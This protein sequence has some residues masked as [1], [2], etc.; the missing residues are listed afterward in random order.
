MHG[1]SAAVGSQSALPVPE[2]DMQDVF[3]PVPSREPACN[4]STVKVPL[5]ADHLYVGA[6]RHVPGLTFKFAGRFGGYP[7]VILFDTGASGSFVSEKWLSHTVTWQEYQQLFKPR[8]LE[9]PVYANTADNNSA[10]I[11]T[12]CSGPLKIQQALMYIRPFV[13]GHLLHGVDVIVGMDALKK[14][15]V[16]LNC[17]FDTATVR[18][19]SQLKT[20]QGKHARVFAKDS[21]PYISVCSSAQLREANIAHLSAKQA[22]KELKRGAASWLMLVQPADQPPDGGMHACAA[23]PTN[24]EPIDDLMSPQTLAKLVSDYSDVFQPRSGCPPHRFDTSHT[25]RLKEGAQPTYR[26]PYRMSIVEEQEMR[27]Q[28]QE[29]L[30]KDLIEPSASPYGAPVLFVQKK[31]GSLRMCVDYRAL[32][33]ITVRDRYPLPRIDELLDRLHGCKVFSSLDLQSG[34]HQIRIADADKEKT[35]MVTSAGQFQFKVLCFGLTN[36]PAT[37]QRVM[38]KI[39][40]PYIGKFVLVYLD[41]ILVMS[42]SAAEHEHHLRT[43]LHI[44]R[45]NQLSAKLSK[46]EFNRPQLHFLGHVVGRDGISVDPDKIAVIRDWPVPTNLKQL[47]AFLGLANYFRRFV[48]HYSMIAA[49]LTELCGKK[50]ETY[51]WRNWG[52]DEL[53]AFNALKKALTTAPVLAIPDLNKPFKV[54]TDASVRGTGAILMQDDRVIAYSSAKFSPAQYNYTTGEQELLGLIRALEVWRCY[55]EYSPETIV[56]TDHHPLIHLQNQANL[57]RRQ[58]RWVEFLARF[59]FQIEFTP[60]KS[61]I[62]DIISR[63]PRHSEDM[64]LALCVTP[65][66]ISVAPAVTRQQARNTPPADRPTD[67]DAPEDG[68]ISPGGGESTHATTPACTS[69]QVRARQPTRSGKPVRSLSRPTPAAAD[70]GQV[71]GAG[72]GTGQCEGPMPQ[73]SVSPLT[74]DN[75]LSEIKNAYKADPFFSTETC[76]RGFARDVQGLWLLSDK[77]VVPNVPELRRKILWLCHDSLM[78]GHPGITKTMDLVAR[79]FFWFGLRKDVEYYVT[80]CEACQRNKASTAQRAGELQPLSIPSRR[81][82]SVSVDF[83]VKLPLTHR[84]HDTIL[85]C[86]DR[87]SKMVHLVP[88]VESTSAAEFARL[89]V[90][91]VVKLHGVPESI[92]SD[93]GPQFASVFWEQ[94][95]KLL[96]IKRAMSSAYHPETDGQTERTN[97][98][99]EEMLRSYVRPDQ[100]DW[101]DYLWCVE[102]AINNSYSQSVKN[103]PFFLNYGQHPLTPTSLDLPKYVPRAQDFTE[104]ISRAVREAKQH[105]GQ[106]RSKYQEYANRFRRP[107]S[108]EPGDMV[109][110]NTK[111]LRGSGEAGVRKLKPR[112]VGPF[113]VIRMIGDAAVELDLPEGWTRIHNVFHVSLVKPYRHSNQ[114]I[115]S[116]APPQPLQW[117]EGEPL[118]EV[119]E[120]LD[121]RFVSR[122]RKGRRQ[123]IEFLVRW[124]GYGPE[125]DT[126]EPRH[127]LLTCNSQIRAYKEARGL[128]PSASDEED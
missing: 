19:G 25:I 53:D 27:R 49:P 32:N 34:Y 11:N 4:L 72:G 1:A 127:N 100:R 88:T 73:R 99:V 13:L 22:A 75:I 44:L 3:E 57:S 21:D 106:A 29:L 40:Q 121:H 104:G 2:V 9:K 39:F 60:G 14:F 110:L 78:S 36:A 84:G 89:F 95:C 48:H 46:C 103:T 5:L 94:V 51:D 64:E 119:E 71:E 56:A 107:V 70:P 126:W 98:V 24:A 61:N 15:A 52:K 109:L 80:H 90:E 33:K 31:D 17:E 85:V 120:I 113:R 115:E 83:V 43:V 77:V 112:F 128:D 108:Y 58:A 59:P 118:Y 117:L 93:R 16:T 26:R 12:M 123:R 62:A 68:L 81:W 101:D 63:N 74:E 7:A 86:V 50:G 82:A 79:Q 125:N 91:N 114:A 45:E 6:A 67:F 23:A 28:I 76:A 47:Q 35:A 38:N 20:I 42:R 8:L 97:R 96:R 55:L 87:L 116:V 65:Y 37:F 105:L 66:G 10:P 102:F 54:I 111:N 18:C 69:P 41:D 30:D 92:I 124:K 122:G